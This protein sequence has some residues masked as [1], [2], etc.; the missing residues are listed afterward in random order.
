MSY[1]SADDVFCDAFMRGMVFTQGPHKSKISPEAYDYMKS[2]GTTW[3]AITPAAPNPGPYLVCRGKLFEAY[4]LYDDTQGAFF[5]G[6]LPSN[7]L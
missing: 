7:D 3:T 1:R 2:L 6:I 4:R 5:T